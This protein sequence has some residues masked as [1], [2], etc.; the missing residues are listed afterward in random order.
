ME[1]KKQPSYIL[2]NE[3]EHPKEYL[4]AINPPV[5]NSSLHLF[6]NIT[7]YY[8][9]ETRKPGQYFY[10]RV[11]NPTTKVAESKIA[12][13]E[14]GRHALIYSSGM[15]AATNAVLHAVKYQSHIVCVK[16]AYSVLTHFIE[17]FLAL[18]MG[19]TITYVDG[20]TTQEFEEAIQ[21]NTD[22]II[23]ESPV[24]LTF[25]VQ[26]IHE[27]CK[28]AKEKGILTYIDNTYCTP[29]Y[30]NPLDLG[31]DIVMHTCS[32]YFSGHS[33]L[34]AGVLVCND[35]KLYQDL[36]LLREQTGGILDPRASSELIKGMRTLQVRV[37]AHSKIAYDVATFLENNEHIK[38]VYYPG[39]SSHP[40]HDLIK[41]QQRKSTGL[42]S[43]EL[44]TTDEQEIVQFIDRL[45]V[46]KIGVSWGG[47]ESLVCTP[48]LMCS[49][50]EANLANCGRGII[51]IHCGL[52]GSE[53]L[54]QDLKQSLEKIA[55]D[56]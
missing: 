46:F 42:L 19:V 21:E 1:I 24:S 23:L 53:I 39:L 40:Q 18:K 9:R 17:S 12:T 51:R 47:F 10:G 45:E 25:S 49:E 8:K 29:L 27:V 7:E 2:L 37:E 41:K 13:L 52:E 6:N 15:A 26:D 16:N 22:L 33:D 48:M 30:Q 28:L 20:F 44:K 55:Y 36:H 14:H 35:E 5:Y 50:E 31:V 4:N 3:G 34:I 43:F 56:K 38:K 11:D 54:I 32:K